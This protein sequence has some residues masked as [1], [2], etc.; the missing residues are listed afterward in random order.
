[1]YI[2]NNPE[3]IQ[4]NSRVTAA[5]IILCARNALLLI[6]TNLANRIVVNPNVNKNT[7]EYG[8]WLFSIFRL[9]FL[10]V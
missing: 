6:H 3:Q 2:N 4:T 8:F 7:Y 9:V 1:M 10:A 5:S